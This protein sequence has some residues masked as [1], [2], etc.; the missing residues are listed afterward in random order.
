MHELSI[1]LCIV[2]IATEEAQKHGDSKAR[3]CATHLKLG[4]LAGVAKEA[5][6][7]AYELACE[8]TPLEGS[9]LVIDEVPIVIDCATCQAE[10]TASRERW[11][12]CPVCGATA[13]R[14]VHGKELEVAALELE[15]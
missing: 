13:A 14:V 5:L 6:V 12:C 4:P 9:R 11:F 7:S 8:G 2:D 10:R 3:V 15:S 1:A